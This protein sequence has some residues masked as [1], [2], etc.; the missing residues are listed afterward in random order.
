MMAASASPI[1]CALAAA[2]LFGA[3]TPLAKLLLGTVPPLLLAALLY[4]GSGI[5]LAAWLVLR[6]AGAQVRVSPIARGDWPWLAGAIAAGGIAG[7]VLL[8]YG[9][10]RTNAGTASLLLNLE[11]VLTAMLAWFAFRENVDRRVFLGMCAIVAGGVVLTWNEAPRVESY[12]G[13]LLVAAACLA[14][15]IDN[16]LTRKVSG[17]DAV[18]IA[19]LKGLAA[20]SVNL[21][22]ALGMGAALPSAGP[23]VAAGLLGLAGYG[24]SL[25]LFIVALRGLGTARTG[26]Y[27]SV[28]PFFGAA[29]ALMLPGEQPDAAFWIAA[30]LMAAGVWLHLS[31]RHDHVHSH[32]PLEH[33][34]MHSH[35]EHHRHEHEPGWDGREPHVHWH[36]HE[37]LSHAHAHYPDLHHR[38]AHR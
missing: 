38:H 9:L 18:T 32:E 22:L 3:S 13:P 30:A 1:A 19:C 14:W 27:Y 28:A 21:A 10:A 11:A 15:A 26:A 31:E 34:H 20:G 35:D 17:G 29:L 8:M 5:G 16:N 2:A 23:L 37:P 4:L 7:P 12:A 24:V 25:V 36:R 33:E 6:R